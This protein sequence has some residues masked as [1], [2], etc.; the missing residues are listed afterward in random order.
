VG[1]SLIIVVSRKNKSLS[2]GE[3]LLLFGPDGL[4]YGKGLPRRSASLEA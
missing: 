1:W 4:V 3:G 2:L